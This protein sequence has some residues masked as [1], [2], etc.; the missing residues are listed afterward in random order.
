MNIAPRLR[1]HLWAGAALVPASLVA[2]L[3]CWS[4]GGPAGPGSTLPVDEASATVASAGN[5]PATGDVLMRL[6][7]G[8]ATVT[9][10]DT[11]AA[12]AFAAM[13]PLRVTL[14]DPMGQAKSGP[15]PSPI[16]VTGAARVFDPSVGVLYYW[17]PSHT[18]AVFYDDLDQSVPAPGLVRLGVVNGGLAAIRSAGNSYRVRIEP[19]AGTSTA[20]GP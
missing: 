12:R 18:V 11:P 9:L 1:P 4:L 19:A 10:D 8:V 3:A 20:M 7:D 13:L 15:L 17:A 6:P 14:R 16:D 5:V 2:V